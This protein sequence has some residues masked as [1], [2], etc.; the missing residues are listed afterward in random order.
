MINIS[1]ATEDVLTEEVIIKILMSFE[2]FN[3]V[4]KLGRQGSGYL[5]S[6]LVNFNQLAGNQIVLLVLDLDSKDSAEEYKRLI[7]GKIQNKNDSLLILVPVR[8]IESWILADRDGLSS[9]LKIS[10]DRI[11]RDPESLLDPKEKI[12]SLSRDCKNGDAK[13]GI[14]PKAGAA[15]KV[16]LSY[17]TLL[18]NFVRDEWSHTRAIENA[19][20]LVE[21]IGIIDSIAHV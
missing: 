6:K 9:F 15:S 2:Q 20:S 1:I 14:P 11:Q 18:T 5:T 13:R 19:P 8:E 7:E 16:G 17:N 3:I 12:I 10:R 4:H 21:T